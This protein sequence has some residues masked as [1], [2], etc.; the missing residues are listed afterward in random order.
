MLI[1]IDASRYRHPMPTG[2]EVYS[3]EIIDGL[4]KIAEKQKTH[5]VILYTPKLIPKISTKLQRIIPG[6]RLWTQRHL[7]LEMKTNPPEILFVP[8][9][10]LPL[11][12]PKKSV[13]TIHDVA[14]QEFPS[15]YSFAQY[16]YLHWSTK[17]A[18]KHTWKIIVPS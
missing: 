10:V 4:I 14:F 18:V 6:G 13:I 16:S 7:S 11:K 15:A 3:D 8:S 9:H 12:H 1:G 5:Q 17:F 2:V